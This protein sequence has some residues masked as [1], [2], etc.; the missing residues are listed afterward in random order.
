MAIRFGM[1]VVYSRDLD[2][3]IEFYR[4]LG[5]EIPDPVEGRPVSVYRDDSYAMVIT[6][7]ALAERFDS[8]WE[9][10]ERGYGQV[11]EFFVD[12]DAS[13]DAVWA[14]ITSAGFTGLTAPGRLIGP[15]A[16]MLQDPDGAAVL[17]SHDPESAAA[18]A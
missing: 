2:R 3:S 9:F 7:S 18:A 14:R 6:T 4:T 15:Y 8:S 11:M 16:T 13:V 17:V 1:N 12:D 5:L 10:P